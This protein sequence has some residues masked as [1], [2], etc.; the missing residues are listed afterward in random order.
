MNHCPITYNPCGENRY[1]DQGL[2]LLSAELTSLNDL[3]Y[4]AEEQRKEA[5]N[6]ALRMSVQGV[7]PKLSARLNVK[8]RKFDIVDSGGRY[9]LKPQH[10][11]FPEMPENEDLTMKL[12]GVTGLDIPLHGLVWSK[13]NTL[14]YFVKRFDRKGQNEKVQVEDLAQL[15][16]LN[17]DTKYNY[18]M[19]KIVSL[20]DKFCTFPSIEKIVLFKLVLFNYIIGNDDMH[21]KNFSLITENGKVR[22]SPC[23]D[24]LN[25]T[26]E[27]SKPDDEIALP[28]K[29]KKKHLTQNILITYF[30]IERCGLT[31]KSVEKVL[32]SISSAIPAWKTLIDSSFLSPGMKEKYLELLNAR[33]KKLNF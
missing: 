12:A 20:I 8:E 15:A 10:Q 14:T 16:G 3:E 32:D 29:G 1:S 13:D 17:R 22:M 9:I 4:T 11:Y 18:S 33:L 7:Q 28:L 31:I 24:L 19:E 2:K 30:G 26:I 23:Y 5:F 21:L 6:R 25:T 27:Y